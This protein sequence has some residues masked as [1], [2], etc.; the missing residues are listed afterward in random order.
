MLQ[1][2]VGVVSSFDPRGKRSELVA[3][4]SQ[5]AQ[6]IDALSADLPERGF[7]QNHAKLAFGP[8]ARS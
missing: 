2:N 3:E 5:N 6:L 4:L 7:R 1:A 8:T